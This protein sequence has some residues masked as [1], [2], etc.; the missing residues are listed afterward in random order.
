MGKWEKWVEYGTFFKGSSQLC[1]TT[2]MCAFYFIVNHSG[3]GRTFHAILH[4]Q[5]SG[6]GPVISFKVLT[7]HTDLL[8]VKNIL[9][10]INK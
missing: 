2:C 4:H 1:Y 3:Q 5:S 10:D 7:Q 8:N 6:Q 9:N